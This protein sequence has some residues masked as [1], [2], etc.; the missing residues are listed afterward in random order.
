MFPPGHISG[1]VD[2]LTETLADPVAAGARSRV[3]QTSLEQR[4]RW[5]LIAADTVA[6]YQQAIA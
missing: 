5:D 3:A 4:F 1:L 2:A 6:V